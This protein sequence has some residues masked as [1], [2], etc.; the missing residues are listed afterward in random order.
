M[1]TIKNVS[2][3]LVNLNVPTLH[4]RRQL[5]P[6]RKIPISQEEYEEIIYDPGINTMITDHYIKIEG[7][8]QEQVVQ[9]STRVYE[10]SN[11]REIYENRNYTAFANFLPKA[12]PAEKETAV[13]LAI[14]L[15]ITDSGFTKLI[16]KY[17]NVDVISAINAKHQL[18]Q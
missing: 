14:E 15:G 18:E 16:E 7:I 1:I 3:A 10:P 4:F 13:Q 5:L 17:C 12:A 6:G 2:T 11:I 9:V 8:P